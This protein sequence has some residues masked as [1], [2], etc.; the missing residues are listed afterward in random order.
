MAVSLRDCYYCHNEIDSTKWH[1]HVKYC[2]HRTNKY[3]YPPETHHDKDKDEWTTLDNA[4]EPIDI[5]IQQ[6]KQH[7]KLE[8]IFGNCSMETS[9]KIKIIQY[10][11][12]KYDEDLQLLPKQ[13]LEDEFNMKLKVSNDIGYD[14]MVHIEEHANFDKIYSYNYVSYCFD[15]GPGVVCN[16]PHDSAMNA[17]EQLCGRL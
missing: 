13:F 7:C 14:N 5:T 15:G 3:R 12:E 6:N 8:K 17:A 9:Q 4:N 16:S 10:M 2:K 1:V 11:A